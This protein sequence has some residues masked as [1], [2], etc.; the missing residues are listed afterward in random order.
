MKST[1]PKGAGIAVLRALA[2]ARFAIL[3]VGVTYLVSVLTG[4]LMVQS[5]NR[6]ALA[7]RDRVVARAQASSITLA[8]D[9]NERLHAALLDFGANLVG[10]LSDTLDGL[11]VILPYSISAYRGWIGGIVSVDGLHSSR[12]SDP[13]EAT[14]YLTTLVLQL[15]PYTLAGGMGVNLGLAFFRPQP[16]YRGS[17]WLEIPKEA[18]RDTFRIYLLI[19]PLFLLASLWEF[20]M[21]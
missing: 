20:G 14:Y 16:D 11:G 13:R 9:R 2:R 10:G 21:R 5:G 6:F 18:V 1:S 15:I 4:M 19:V 8:L 17:K 3:T 7:Y 12:L